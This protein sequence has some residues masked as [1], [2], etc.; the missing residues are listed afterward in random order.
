MIH[1]VL[2]FCLFQSLIQELDSER[3]R[4]WKAEQAARRMV[5]AVK[6]MQIKGL[7]WFY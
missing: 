5:D 2:L 1:D 3:E 4:R 6:E 7:V